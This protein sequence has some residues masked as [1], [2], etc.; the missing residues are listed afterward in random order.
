MQA[1]LNNRNQNYNGSS[2]GSELV[3]GMEVAKLHGVIPGF[4]ISALSLLTIAEGVALMC[5]NQSWL[6]SYINV[7]VPGLGEG[8]RGQ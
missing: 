6:H 1:K 5:Q 3:M 8:E 2:K 7:R 4:H